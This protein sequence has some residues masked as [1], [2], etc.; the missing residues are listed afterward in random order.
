M[1]ECLVLTMGGKDGVPLRFLRPVAALVATGTAA[2]TVGLSV[3]PASADQIRQQEWW[4]SGLSIT[5]CWTASQ[6]SGVTV[7]VLSDGVDGSHPDLT[8]VVSAAPPTAIPSAPVATGQFFGEQ[9]TPIASLIAGHG[10]GSGDNS[11]I[12]GV[13]PEAH[14]L[15]VPVTLPPDDPQIFEQSVGAAIPDAIAAGIRYAVS[16][17]ASVIDLPIDPGQPGSDGSGGAAAAA[18]GSSA[19]QSAVS[20]ALAHNV[21]LVAPAGDDATTTGEPNYPAAY[22]GV[23][24]VGAF[25]SAF[26]K[27]PWTSRLSYVTL[28]AAGAGVIAASNSGGYE[29]MNSTSAASAIVAGIVALIRSRYP[30]LSVADVRTALT[31]TTMFHRANGLTDGSG[32]GAVNAAAAFGAAA[33]LATPASDRAGADAEPPTTLRPAAAGAGV[34][35]LS[36]QIVR[37][38]EI[39]VGV[40]VLLLLVVAGY[41][42]VSRRRRPGGLP[43]LA[44]EWTAGQTQSR[45]PHAVVTAT[46]ADRM[47]EYFAAPTGPPPEP[48]GQ[49]ARTGGPVTAAPPGFGD[50][51]DA[52]FA[53]P[54]SSGDPGTWAPQGPASRPVAK[55]TPVS[56]TPPW[57]PAAPPDGVLPWSDPGQQMVTGQV[58]ASGLADA[59]PEPADPGPR[60]RRR[61]ADAEPEPA[62]PGP[63][64]R[65]RPD[66]RRAVVSGVAPTGGAQPEPGELAFRPSPGPASHSAGAGG[67][68]LG[69][70]ADLTAPAA[71]WGSAEAGGSA[72]WDPDSR[73]SGQ[74]R[75]SDPG[76]PSPAR[77]A[78][79]GQHRSGLPIRQPRS[80]SQVPR[81][82]SGSLWEPAPSSS[83]ASG[84]GE[85]LSDTG[86][87]H[88]RSDDDRPIF[89]W[90]PS[91]VPADTDARRSAD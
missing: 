1:A 77:D 88:T 2:M 47:L 38:G 44:A 22:P 71:W 31:T 23:I 30:G 60:P 90:E 89:V 36:P 41:A 3:A 62:D 79:S 19:E 53:P 70:R 25:D 59:E 91:G 12:I 6:G 46:E 11:G 39:S 33:T 67:Q 85:R 15:S 78:A 49:L 14:I 86:L 37:A 75:Y 27:A 50:S 34:A 58:V 4:L 65:R 16:Q 63:R 43:A 61:L 21:V 84:G 69:S 5:N 81:S 17:G 55:R 66:W 56:G 52:V 83:S 64:P 24:A 87:P 72:D 10:D 51:D 74:P 80:I 57:E 7:A 29:T 28:T 8:G 54:A 32:Y 35:K 68:G 48:G 73:S 18:G 82:A 9:G 20:Y 42:V 40:L 26:V 13:A 76:P 45:Y